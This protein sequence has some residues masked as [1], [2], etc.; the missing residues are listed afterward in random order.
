[1]SLYL[2]KF[3][4]AAGDNDRVLSVGREPDTAAPVS[5]TVILVREGGGGRGGGEGGEG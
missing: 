1:M 5:V 3:V 2:D 4:P